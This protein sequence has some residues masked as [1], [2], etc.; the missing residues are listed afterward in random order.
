LFLLGFRKSY[1]FASGNQVL[2]LLADVI[3]WALLA[4]EQKHPTDKFKTI[5]GAAGGKMGIPG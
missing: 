3:I 2:A 5:T 4:K 1:N